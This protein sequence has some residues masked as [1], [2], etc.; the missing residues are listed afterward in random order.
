MNIVLVGFMGTGKTA[1]A[2]EVATKTAMEYVS[3]DQVIEEKEGKSINDIFASFGEKYFRKLEKEVARCISLKDNLIIDAGGGIVL[4][5]ENVAALKKTGKMICLTARPDVIHRRTKKR[6]HRPLLN[7][8][9]P[10]VKIK[11]LLQYRAAFYK[12]AD[13]QID[14]SDKGI[15]EVAE[16]VMKLAGFRK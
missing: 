11:E 14:T 2:R 3:V 12:R 10:M 6:T 4:D 1:V 16:E 13:F 5:E 7:V 15:K 8:A 9:N